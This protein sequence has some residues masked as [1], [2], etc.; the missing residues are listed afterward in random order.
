[1]A[2]KRKADK[3][4]YVDLTQEQDDD[5]NV[6]EVP[7]KRQ[8]RPK[9]SAEDETGAGPS[10]QPE[11][12]AGAPKPKGKRSPGKNS[13]QEETQ[14]ALEAV[15]AAA[16]PKPKGRKKAQSDEERRVSPSGATVAYRPQPSQKV[17][18]RI[19][20]AMPGSGHRMFLVD[21]TPL[22]PPGAEGGAAAEYHV[23]GA[24]G[25]VY[26]VQVSRHPHCSCPDFDRGHLCKHWLFVLLRVLRRSQDDPLIWQVG[27]NARERQRSPYSGKDSRACSSASRYTKTR[28]C[29]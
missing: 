7:K 16:P 6:I 27:W 13:S 28:V 5:D 24:T 22:R 3:Y 21:S 25:N 2:P 15:L 18:E 11:S 23:L 14:V 10:Q 4:A 19:A 1:M 8:R 9:K 20:R 29:E 12:H 17:Q 26:R